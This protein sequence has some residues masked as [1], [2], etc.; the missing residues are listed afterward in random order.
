MLTIE[1]VLT[2]ITVMTVMVEIFTAIWGVR[3]HL[4]KRDIKSKAEVWLYDAQGIANACT[5][6]KE[7]CKEGRAT[8]KEAGG[9]VNTIGS[10][11]N[12]LFESIKDALNWKEREPK[13]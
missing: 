4:S 7:D 2:A 3:E 8:A 5:V 10:D 11:A 1:S 12:S 13:P 6:L 9:R